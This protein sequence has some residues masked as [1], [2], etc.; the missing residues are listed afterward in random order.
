M[1]PRRKSN[2]FRWTEEFHFFPVHNHDL[3]QT[4]C[5]VEPDRSDVFASF[6]AHGRTVAHYDSPLRCYF[7]VVPH[8]DE[9]FDL[10]PLARSM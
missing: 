3:P 9:S 2:F 7:T 4:K 5:F 1:T 6:I 8:N 10:H